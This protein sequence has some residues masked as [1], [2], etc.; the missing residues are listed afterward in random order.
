[1]ADEADIKHEKLELEV[2]D[3][4][5]KEEED[6]DMD[7]IAL[8]PPVRKER[9]VS[10]GGGTP[11][12]TGTPRGSKTQ[13]RSP[14]KSESKAETPD[15]EGKVKVDGEVEVK[16][17]PDRPPLLQRKKS[18]KIERRPPQLFSDY[19]NKTAEAT[20]TFSIL[21]ECTYANKYLG[22]TEH[23]LECDCAEEWGK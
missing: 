11:A 3:M 7:T 6:A 13:S 23:A 12:S 9:S 8:A 19:E 5:I 2:K 10:T 1:M 20:S 22:T 4:N 15:G 18:Q 17:L 21:T 16:I 14:M